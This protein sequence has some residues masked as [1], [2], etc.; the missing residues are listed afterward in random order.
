M[1]HISWITFIY[2]MFSDQSQCLFV[3]YA[4][5]FQINT[6]FSEDKNIVVNFDEWIGSKHLCSTSRSPSRIEALSLTCSLQVTADSQYSIN[7]V[8]KAYTCVAHI[9]KRIHL[10]SKAM[11]GHYPFHGNCN[12]YYTYI[13]PV[14]NTQIRHWTY[15]FSCY[16]SNSRVFEITDW[17]KSTK[18]PWM[19]LLVFSRKNFSM[20]NT[21]LP[22]YM[23]RLVNDSIFYY[24]SFLGDDFDCF[25]LIRSWP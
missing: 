14:C 12:D 15:V 25:E 5:D 17:Y 4:C 22:I 8:I 6:T 21:K 13:V 7:T 18:R 23:N 2:R 24:S 9:C 1:V 19:K 3:W 20:H 16:I 11:K 10:N